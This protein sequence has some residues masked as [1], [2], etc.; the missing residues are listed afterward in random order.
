MD[1]FAGDGVVEVQE[2]G[3]QE[4]A[5]IAGEAGEMFKWLAGCSV[6]RIA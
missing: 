2:L 5:S 1:W 3:M 4:V 6:E